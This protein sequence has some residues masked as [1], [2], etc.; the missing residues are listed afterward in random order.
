MPFNIC[1]SCCDPAAQS[2]GEPTWRFSVL[3]VLCSILSALQGGP[4]ALTEA[5]HEF[6]STAFGA[7]TNAFLVALGNAQ[8]LRLLSVRNYT[9]A[10]IEISTDG[11]NVAF[12]VPASRAEIR[13]YAADGMKVS[14][15]IYL[16][17]QSGAPTVG[18]VEINGAY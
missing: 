17:Y 15:D 3:N 1:Q 18:S 5:N 9:D 6:N 8:P 12:S 14:T 2:R 4:A 16:R 10:T 7:I 11:V 13:D